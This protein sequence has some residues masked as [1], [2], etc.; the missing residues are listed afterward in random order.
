MADP[1]KLE[2]ELKRIADAVERIAGAQPNPPEFD[3]VEG[4]VWVADGEVFHPVEHISRMP[5]DLLKGIDQQK[6][7][8]L[9]NTRR[10]ANGL[11]ANNALL[12]GARG[13]G[14]SSLVKAAH[15]A[16]LIERDK[17]NK[18]SRS[19]LK[20]L[21]IHR[22]EIASLPQCLNHLRISPH[23]FIVFCDDFVI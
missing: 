12:W 20:I 18:K 8:L 4:F 11:P 7:S 14:K 19:G 5:I 2:T 10:F 3:Q 23:R 9:E 16:I 1:I 6:I 13:A 17:D 15:R 21:E 22:E